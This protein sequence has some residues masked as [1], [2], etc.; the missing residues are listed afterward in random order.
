MKHLS[1]LVNGKDSE[2]MS[3]NGIHF[4][5]TDDIDLSG[6]NWIPIGGV[7]STS[8]STITNPFM[9]SFDGGGYVISGLNIESSEY[10]FAGLFG[11]LR[12]EGEDGVTISNLIIEGNIELLS[13]PVP[14]SSSAATAGLITGTASGKITIDS[15]YARSGSVTAER[16]AGIIGEAEGTAEGDVQVLSCINEATVNGRLGEGSKASAY[17]GGILGS[18]QNTHITECE[19]HGNTA[20]S[21]LTGGIV[22]YALKT[23]DITS[24]SN[25]GEIDGSGSSTGGITGSITGGSITA[26]INYAS[27]TSSKSQ[28]GGIAGTAADTAIKDCKVLPEGEN[29]ITIKSN[30]SVGGIAGIL[31]GTSSITGETENRAEILSMFAGADG[32]GG[33]AGTV[34]DSASIDGARNY[35]SVKAAEEASA[36]Q[37]YYAGGIAGYVSG[38]SISN[39]ENYGEIGNDA[40]SPFYGVGGIA[41]AV[42]GSGSVKSSDNR[43]AVAGDS[44]TG[45]IAGRLSSATINDC[46]NY[47]AVTA[48]GNSSG[49]FHSSL[50]KVTLFLLTGRL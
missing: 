14:S 8:G 10:Q 19:N 25:Y 20:S 30:S 16:A 7:G 2:A 41:G 26:S 15:C 43:G 17:A 3:L 11:A 4:A 42:I 1:D 9:G 37:L 27:V 31:S 49:I 44:W 18:A 13:K 29:T 45:G 5:L 24:C 47:A 32:K 22:G 46:N 50:T 12:G 35:G 21:M 48:N 40:A 34:K 23:T 33:I 39:T 36:S 28:T 6:E 38:G